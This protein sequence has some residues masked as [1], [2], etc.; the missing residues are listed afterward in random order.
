MID[1]IKMSDEK[2][3]DV[4]FDFCLSLLDKLQNASTADND[5]SV[6]SNLLQELVEEATHPDLQEVIKQSGTNIGVLQQQFKLKVMELKGEPLPPPD[7]TDYVALLR[8]L[9]DP[10]ISDG[11]YKPTMNKLLMEGTLTDDQR[12]QVSIIINC[13]DMKQREDMIDDFKRSFIKAKPK[14]K[15]EKK[16]EG[17]KVAPGGGEGGVEQDYLKGDLRTLVSRL[18]DP[19]YKA[20]ARAIYD[21]LMEPGVDIDYKNVAIKLTMPSNKG[22]KDQLLAEFDR[23]M[24]IRKENEEK[25]KAQEEEIRKIALERKKIEDKKKQAK[26]DLFLKKRAEERRN[27]HTSAVGKLD[28]EKTEEQRRIEREKEREKTIQ[29]LKKM[30]EK[31]RGPVAGG[32]SQDVKDDRPS[33][34]LLP[35][36]IDSK[37]GE[38]SIEVCE[39]TKL[40]T[41]TESEH[42]QLH[43]LLSPFRNKEENKDK[44]EANKVPDATDSN[45]IDTN[46]D[47]PTEANTT[48][49]PHTN[50]NKDPNKELQT[51][52]PPQ[53]SEKVIIRT[54]EFKEYFEKFSDPDLAE[55]DEVA[56]LKTLI[57]EKK[58][59]LVKDLV[60]ELSSIPGKGKSKM[61][62]KLC[63]RY[64]GERVYKQSLTTSEAT[65]QV[66]DNV[67]TAKTSV[68]NDANS[69]TG[70]EES[71]QE[72][73][74]P[75]TEQTSNTEDKIKDSDNAQN[76]K[77]NDIQGN[78]NENNK[79]KA[80]PMETDVNVSETNK[81]IE[82][83]KVEKR[84]DETKDINADKDKNDSEEL[85]IKSK[86][87]VTTEKSAVKDKVLTSSKDSHNSVDREESENTSEEAKEGKNEIATNEANKDKEKNTSKESSKDKENKKKDKTTSKEP[88]K[89]KGAIEDKKENDIVENGNTSKTEKKDEEKS[90]K[91]NKKNV[92]FRS[93]SSEDKSQSILTLSMEDIRTKFKLKRIDA[94]V[95]I[96]KNKNL[97]K[98][99]LGQYKND[100]NNTSKRKLNASDNDENGKRRKLN[101][102]FSHNTVGTVDA[103]DEKETRMTNDPKTPINGQIKSSDSKDVKSESEGIVN[104]IGASSQLKVQTNKSESKSKSRSLSRSRS[105][106]KSKSR[107]LSRS[108][109]RSASRSKSSSRSI[110]RSRS[111][112]KSRSLS[113]RSRSRS[114]TRS[115][116][117]S[118]S[119]SR[120]SSR[121]S[122]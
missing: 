33:Y 66:P 59:E 58:F 10:N 84:D 73:T 12:H 82:D 43:K 109:S 13:K 24:R 9:I 2:K 68:Q 116:S 75:S 114:L 52:E 87:E 88:S 21:R 53:V 81:V 121:S 83:G 69:K 107:S 120:S 94:H 80:E 105:R 77:M 1:N 16:V 72:K 23:D 122:R 97:Y 74:K 76:S 98:A 36:N 32:A 8:K 85:D 118:R 6:A 93:V 79:E 54:T 18:M 7:D 92:R 63:D 101:P 57:S 41:L 61:F 48:S 28:N 17:D 67:D 96:K 11:E 86:D 102:L 100:V 106:S 26:R 90:T 29:E 3:I 22:L 108:R 27:K 91:A 65:K 20:V 4:D 51:P 111:R 34:I 14:K 104:G 95:K 50:P 113:S 62:S 47:G 112:S 44:T 49:P 19:K 99:Y 119:K 46:T 56:L 40:P 31:N 30:R 25:K 103:T 45:N 70:S 89:N 37:L 78:A 115:R 110:S 71:E 42:K 5:A 55:A 38:V 39:V 117:R 15:K 35:W 60:I 64:V